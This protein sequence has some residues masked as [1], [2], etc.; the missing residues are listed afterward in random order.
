[1]LVNIELVG[2]NLAVEYNIFAIVKGLK[3]SYDMRRT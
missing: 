3:P 1:M 2:K